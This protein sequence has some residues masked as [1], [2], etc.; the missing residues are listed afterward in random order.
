MHHFLGMHQVH[1][2]SHNVQQA[3]ANVGSL[4][5][6]D[7]NSGIAGDDVHILWLS[8]RKVNVTGIEDHQM[9]DLSIGTCAGVTTTNQGLVVVILHQYAYTG[10]GRMI[11]SSA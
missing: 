2:Q 5:D 7:C 10:K 8:D 9:S 3:K 4:V 6:R 11:H 1:Y